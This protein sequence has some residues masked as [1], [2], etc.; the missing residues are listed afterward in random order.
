MSMGENYYEYYE[1]GLEEENG[2]S[3]SNSSNENTN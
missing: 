2:S 3:G 1:V